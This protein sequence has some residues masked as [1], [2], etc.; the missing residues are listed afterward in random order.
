MKQ[1]DETWS[2]SEKFY[3]SY[4]DVFGVPAPH[5]ISSFEQ[6]AC[7]DPYPNESMGK[8]TNFDIPTDDLDFVYSDSRYRKDNSPNCIY[9]PSRRLMLKIMRACIGVTKEEDLWYQYEGKRN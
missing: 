7:F 2:L 9:I 1:P 4:G 3:K 5:N 6:I 8:G